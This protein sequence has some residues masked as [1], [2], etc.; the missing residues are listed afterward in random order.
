VDDQPEVHG[1]PQSSNTC[2]SRS[3]LQATPTPSS[4]PK[5]QE[6]KEDVSQVSLLSRSSA[7]SRFID[8]PDPFLK[9]PQACPKTSARVLTSSVNIQLIAEKEKRKEEEKAL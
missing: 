1:N 2:A 9:P 4:A 8:H 3:V 5:L 7:L 6:Y